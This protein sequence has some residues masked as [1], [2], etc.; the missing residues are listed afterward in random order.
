MYGEGE[1]EKESFVFMLGNAS[2]A[3]IME[4]PISSELNDEE[5]DK[6]TEFQDDFDSEEEKRQR[7]KR[8]VKKYCCHATSL[9]WRDYMRL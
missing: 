5:S 8:K 2:R 3:A 4:S 7:K 9:P 1:G 6:E